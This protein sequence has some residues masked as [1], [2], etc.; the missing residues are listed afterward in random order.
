MASKDG[1]IT[2]GVDGVHIAVVRF[3]RCAR[4]PPLA[5]AAVAAVRPRAQALTARPRRSSDRIG[6][7]G[8]PCVLLF[9]G[10]VRCV[11]NT[12]KDTKRNQW[13]K[14]QQ[15]LTKSSFNDLYSKYI[16]ALTFEGPRCA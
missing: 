1:V 9:Q 11:V 15:I 4:P 5:S 10:G 16:R 8:V 7:F 14:V 12:K 2:V 6:R 13:A 3:D